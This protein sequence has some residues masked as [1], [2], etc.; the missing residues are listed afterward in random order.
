MDVTRH[1]SRTSREFHILWTHHWRTDSTCMLQ[2]GH[3]CF[4]GTKKV[5]VR[6]WSSLVPKSDFDS[7]VGVVVSPSMTPLPTRRP[8]FLSGFSEG[9]LSLT[10]HVCLRGVRLV[11]NESVEVYKLCR[12]SSVSFPSRFSILVC[13]V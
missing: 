1:V 4:S 6:K 3:F 7:P 8:S 13:V 10:G 11:P 2:T 5:L 12:L 9:S